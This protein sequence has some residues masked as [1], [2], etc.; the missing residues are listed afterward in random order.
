MEITSTAFR[1][2]TYHRGMIYQHE[3]KDSNE[4]TTLLDFRKYN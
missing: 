3:K 1:P 2:I 4:V